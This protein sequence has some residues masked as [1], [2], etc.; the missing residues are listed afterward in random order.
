MYRNMLGVN[1]PS[2]KLRY[3]GQISIVENTA[4]YLKDSWQQWLSVFIKSTNVNQ[5]CDIYSV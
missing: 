5:I 1:V 4:H 3:R 2:V